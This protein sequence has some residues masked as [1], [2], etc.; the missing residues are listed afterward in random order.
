MG[1]NACCIA[2]FVDGRR[3]TARW[4]CNWWR[5]SAGVVASISCH[6]KVG[7][8]LVK[9]DLRAIHL[10][11]I[12]ADCQIVDT[13]PN[14]CANTGCANSGLGSQIQRRW[15]RNQRPIHVFVCR[16]RDFG[17]SVRCLRGIAG[18]TANSWI[19]ERSCKRGNLHDSIRT[20]G[21][22]AT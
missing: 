7:V 4:R 17:R 3:E 16:R 20:L 1:R 8:G 13:K 18:I 12:A 10:G 2:R 9:G 14:G 22:A 19:T 11:G 5:G 15:G 21:P 6:Y